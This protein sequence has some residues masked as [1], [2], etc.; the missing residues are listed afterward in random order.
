MTNMWNTVEA[1]AWARN[2]DYENYVLL[3]KK[4]FPTGTPFKKETYL[5]FCKLFGSTITED[6]D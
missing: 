6:A 1:A 3:Y 2:F 4:V 5:G